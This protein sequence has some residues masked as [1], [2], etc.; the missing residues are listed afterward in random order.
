MKVLQLNVW[1]GRL[2]RQIMPLIE[3]EQPDIITA[4]EIFDVEG[5]VPLP[6]R[7]FTLTQEI[8]ATGMF[9]YHYFS[10]T[11][12]MQVA[13][14]NA[15]FGN[16]I[17]SKYPIVNAETIFNYGSFVEG[18][19]A[20]TVQ[21]NTRNAQ[22][23]TLAVDGVEMLV[24]NHHAYWEANPLGS[25]T[26]AD[27][28]AVIADRLH[29]IQE[30]PIIFAGDLNLIAEAPAMRVFDGLL[31][32]L[33]ATHHIVSTLSPLGK[34][35]DIACDHILVNEQVDVTDFRV[36]EAIVSDHAALVLECS[37]SA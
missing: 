32:D 26:S 30:K 37:V 16:A 18:V 17:F 13:G 22:F 5:S 10:A 14:K 3:R 21:P 11:M 27:C 33:T 31:E 25:Q 6:D 8:L 34:V 19:T 12:T 24:V 36:L 28:L 20:D 1:M 9:P 7:M 35:K 23:V 29:E 2:T 4:Q 15:D